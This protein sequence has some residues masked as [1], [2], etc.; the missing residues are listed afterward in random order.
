MQLGKGYWVTILAMATIN[1]WTFFHFSEKE[2]SPFQIYSSLI[3]DN[4]HEGYQSNSSHRKGL[5]HD[6]HKVSFTKITH[7]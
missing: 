3:C 7:S 1:I 2:R 4:N 5:I 6:K